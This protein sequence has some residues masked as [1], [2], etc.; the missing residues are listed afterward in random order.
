MDY[1]LRFLDAHTFYAQICCTLPRRPQTARP[2]A[3]ERWGAAPK[4]YV[5]IGTPLPKGYVPIGTSQVA[6]RGVMCSL[7]IALSKVTKNYLI[8][9]VYAITI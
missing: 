6:R 8:F 7:A 4:G 2:F 9:V 1:P 5:P 3:S